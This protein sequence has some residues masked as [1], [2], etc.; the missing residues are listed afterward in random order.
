MFAIGKKSYGS[1]LFAGLHVIVIAAD[2]CRPTACDTAFKR[3]KS[4]LRN[5]NIRATSNQQPNNKC[6]IDD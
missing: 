1:L 5:I 4:G 6:I 2:R 3:H